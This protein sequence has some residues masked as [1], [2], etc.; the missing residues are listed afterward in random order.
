MVLANLKEI[1]KIVK[2]LPIIS[3]ISNYFRSKYHKILLF[4]ET[5]SKKNKLNESIDN[6]R[7]TLLLQIKSN[8]RVMF[9]FYLLYLSLNE[10]DSFC[11]YYH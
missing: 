3:S 7:L 9:E 1:K 10:A 8:F 11:H 6:H 2:Y 4:H 5:S